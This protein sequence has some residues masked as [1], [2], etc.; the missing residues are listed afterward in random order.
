MLVCWAWHGAAADPEQVTNYHDGDKTNLRPDN[1][2]WAWP[3]ELNRQPVELTSAIGDKL[4]FAG[5]R[6]AER[7]LG[8]SRKDRGLA[9]GLTYGGYRWE[10]VKQP[11]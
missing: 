4:R 1:L 3:A 7:A 5:V 10:K 6:V 9:A 8:L 2:Y 11:A